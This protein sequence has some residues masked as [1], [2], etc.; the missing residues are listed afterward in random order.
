MNYKRIAISSG[1]G[2]LVP[3]ACGILIEVTEA[4][5]VVSE[6]AVLLESRGINAPEFH[7]NVS[8]NQNENLDRIV[9]WHN[10]QDRELDISVH[11]NAFEQCEK[12]MGTEVLY[13]TQVE[14]ADRMSAAIATAGE[15]IDRGPKKN[16]GLAF[17]NG[18]DKPAILIEVCF[19]DS[20][21]DADL[22]GAC[23][24]SICNAIAS[25]IAGDTVD[26]RPPLPEG[27]DG[28]IVGKCS[29]FGGPDDMGVSSSEE[30]AFISEVEQAP[31]LFLPYQPSGTT[32]L[33]RRLN[34]N[35]HYIACRWH[36]D[37]TSKSQ[38]LTKQVWVKSLASGI[39]LTAFPADW[40]P[41]ENTGRVADL[42]PGLMKDLE[43]DT[44]DDVELTWVT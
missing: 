17:L 21:S 10:K 41:N 22:Y 19:V 40:G 18:T 1:H 6:V 8:V 30:L 24:R 33:A 15:F 5:R 43:L 23:F 14:L 12:P 26:D 7:D 20:E 39:K 44:D 36:Y 25:V 38:L 31:H 42:S 28:R 37:V 27:E 11:F 3:G 16:T 9:D 35:I 32:G 34:P 29:W 4:R 2:K 13:V